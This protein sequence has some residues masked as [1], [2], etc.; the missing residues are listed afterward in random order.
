VRSDGVLVATWFGDP[1]LYSID[2]RS[3]AIEPVAS[4]G[5]LITYVPDFAT[6]QESGLDYM[7]IEHVGGQRSL[8]Q[9][10]LFSGERTLVGA[11]G[12]DIEGIAGVASCP[13]DFNADGVLSVLDFVAFQL[14]WQAGDDAADVNGDGVLNVLDFVAF[15]ELFQ[16]GCP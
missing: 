7:L 10:N 2:W 5:E 8:W 11:L 4:L 3:G 6:D 13:A 16:G 12:V 14:A 15:Q 9:V 1:V